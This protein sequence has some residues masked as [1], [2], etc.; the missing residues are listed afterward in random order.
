MTPVVPTGTHGRQRRRRVAAVRADDEARRPVGTYTNDGADPRAARTSPART[1]NR[2]TSANA[3]ARSRPSTSAPCSASRRRSSSAAAS[4]PSSGS[5]ARNRPRSARCRALGVG[6]RHQPR[7]ER[8]VERRHRARRPRRRTPGGR[9]VARAG[10]GSSSCVRAGAVSPPPTDVPPNDGMTSAWM[11]TTTSATL[12]AAR[13][14]ASGL[15]KTP[16]WN[17]IRR[18]PRSVTTR[19]A[20]VRLA[21]TAR[22]VVGDHVRGVAGRGA[23]RAHR[24]R[25]LG[26]HAHL[27]PARRP[28]HGPALAQHV[29]GPQHAHRVDRV[30]G[31]LGL[32][33]AGCRQPRER[34][35]GAGRDRR[36]VAG[37]RE[38]PPGPQVVEIDDLEPLE[39]PPELD[40]VVEDRGRDGRLAVGDAQAQQL[41][42]DELERDGERRGGLDLVQPLPDRARRRAGDRRGGRRPVRTR[43]APR[44]DRVD[45][46]AAARHVDHADVVE[47]RGRD[48]E[49]GHERAGAPAGDR[50]AARRR[51]RRPAGRRPIATSRAWTM[52]WSANIAG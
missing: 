28:Q 7:R 52:P 39:Q 34:V 49:R 14:T 30:V 25:R 36:R 16:R 31:E 47:V 4:P 9:R 22:V 5:A 35:G 23:Q 19:L 46:P 41:P 42:D 32:G 29:G 37:C 11:S 51:R 43:P 15:P 33:A 13:S 12:A 45:P 17:A 48:P 27:E 20:D 2:P 40:A 50:A 8:R 6:D 10:S 3:A 21:G 26:V 18:W 44:P 24:A 38:P 1:V